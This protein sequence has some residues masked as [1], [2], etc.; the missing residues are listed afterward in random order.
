MVA[1]IAE[2][3]PVAARESA[4]ENAQAASQEV[5]GAVRAT[6]GASE[7]SEEARST[8]GPMGEPGSEYIEIR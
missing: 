1:E 7:E 3:A 2:A 5:P 6:S 8:R 4:L